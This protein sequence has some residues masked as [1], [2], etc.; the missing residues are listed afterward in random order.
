MKKKSEPSVSTGADE[1]PAPPSFGEEDSEGASE[2]LEGVNPPPQ[3]E[4]AAETTESLKAKVQSYWDQLLRL[5]A[6]FANYRNR[7]EKEKIEAIRFGREIILEKMI[8]LTD[9]M[10]TALKHTQNPSDMDSLKKG[11]EMVVNEFLG[12][13][14]SQGAEPLKTVGEKFDPHLHEAVEQILTENKEE[15]QTI[16]EEVQKGYLVNGRVLRHAKV[17]VAKFTPSVSPPKLGGD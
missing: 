15:D 7:A 13:L 3:E 10:E 6:E 14:K 12:F 1:S 5:Q 11:F 4:S 16:V 9:V 8:A 17:K 2:K